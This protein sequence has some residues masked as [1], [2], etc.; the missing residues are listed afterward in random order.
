MNPREIKVCFE[1]HKEKIEEEMKLKDSLNH[2]LG[3]YIA[4]G[5]NNPKK[6]PKK[7]FLAKE[8]SSY[9]MTKDSQLDAFICANYERQKKG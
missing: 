8:E 7:P 9:K 2:L 4:I 5:V 1:G 3:K 6:Y